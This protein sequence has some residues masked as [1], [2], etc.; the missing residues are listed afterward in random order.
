MIWW[1]SMS[2]PLHFQV[3]ILC[4]VLWACVRAQSETGFA[5]DVPLTASL[6]CRTL[7]R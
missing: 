2:P 5:S 4:L 3:R 7:E 1:N 6:P